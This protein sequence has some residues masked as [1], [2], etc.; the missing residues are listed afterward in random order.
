MYVT[1]LE[2][3]TK[4]EDIMVEVFCKQC[5]KPF[6]PHPS[7][8]KR[9]GGKFCSRDCYFKSPKSEETLSKMSVATKGKPHSEDHRRKIGEAQKGVPKN[10]ESIEKMRQTKIGLKASPE[11]K[12]KMRECRLGEKSHLWQGG[13][14]FGKYCKR[15]NARFKERQRAYMG[16]VCLLCGSPQNGVKHVPHH[17]N[18]DK[19]VCCNDVKPLFVTLC[20][21]CNT[22]VN[23]NR[24]Y[25]EQYF[26]EI[27]ETYYQG[28]TF[29]TEEEMVAW[30]SVN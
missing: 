4:G 3:R 12:K 18:Y 8:L 22:K 7:N 16:Y 10:R 9:G 30:E 27:I 26:T 21:P 5:G 28:K 23:F 20:R 11:T 17:V 2:Q 19:M 25:W 6:Y 15:F 1:I 13:K 14:S 29:F 24:E